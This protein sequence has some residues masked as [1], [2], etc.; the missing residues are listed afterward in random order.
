MRKRMLSILLSLCMILL[1]IPTGI[2]ADGESNKNISLGLNAL[3]NNQDSF[4]YFGNYKQFSD[5]AGF[6]YPE[7]I[8]WRVLSN[9]NN[10]AWLLSDKILDVYYYHNEN[11]INVSIYWKDTLMKK[12]LNSED[13]TGGFSDKA[14]SSKELDT[15]LLKSADLGKVML[16]SDKEVKNSSWSSNKRTILPSV[17]TAFARVGGTINQTKSADCYILRSDNPDDYLDIIKNDG[18]YDFSI[19]DAGMAFGVRPSMYL[20]NSK[21]LFTSPASGGKTESGLTSVSDYSRNEYKLTV[22]DADRNNFLVTKKSQSGDIIEFDYELAKTGNKEF[23]SAMVVN[24]DTVKYYGRIKNVNDESGTLSLSIPSTVNVNNGDRLFAFNEQCNGDY[25]TDYASP[26]RELSLENSSSNMPLLQINSVTN[27]WE[28]S[29]DNG[30]TWTSLNVKATGETGAKGDKGDTGASGMDGANGADGK[31]GI[32]PM[33]KVDDNNLWHVSYDNGNVWTSLGVKATGAKGDKGDTGAS[34][35]DGLIPHVGTNGN[36]WLD[37]TD[38][39][40]QASVKGDQGENG[41]TP[42]LKIDG[43]N[44][45][46]VSYD[47]GQTWTSLNVKATGDTGTSGRDGING[48]DGKDGITPMLKVGDNNLWHISYDSGNTWM[49]LGTKATGDVGIRGEK[50]DTGLSGKD[51]SNGVDG[52]NG[53]GISNANINEEGELILAYTNGAS[54]NLGRVV[55]EDGLTPYIGD[56]GNWWHGEKDT[57]VSAIA[58]SESDL[59]SSP[60]II[61]IGTIAGLAFISNVGLILYIVFKK[62]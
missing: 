48:I 50:G 6:L 24:G 22:L 30:A 10:T 28:V 61:T 62:K 15:I 58:V 36:W 44:I 40:V 14:F 25:K 56:N 37:N 49:S 38:T 45:W 26:L 34:G 60:V 8:K 13:P 23:I 31:D 43:G 33:L 12:W 53:V 11:S 18:S 55:G 47:G 46:S 2:F 35:K 41:I 5:G 7:P 17:D 21:V 1:F 4:L 57:G 54:I 16:L 59:L 20:D 19:F 51:G 29:Y 52:E 9:E 42:Q 3:N 27:E 32:T 39:G